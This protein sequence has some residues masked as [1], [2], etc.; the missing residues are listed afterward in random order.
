MRRVCV[1]VVST[2]LGGGSIDRGRACSQSASSSLDRST[3]AGAPADQRASFAPQTQANRSIDRSIQPVHA[4]QE[5]QP[6]RPADGIE[7]DRS[8]A[9]GVRR[10]AWAACLWGRG[11]LPRGWCGP[12]PP[13][14]LDT[15]GRLRFTPPP[16]LAAGGQPAHHSSSSSHIPLTPFSSPIITTTASP[17]PTSNHAPPRRRR[18]LRPP[19]PAGAH[20]PTH[21]Y[22]VSYTWPAGSLSAQTGSSQRPWES[23]RPRASPLPYHT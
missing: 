10:R 11:W 23:D 2:W 6:D 20:T 3:R 21:M 8:S 5:R 13:Q 9:A 12:S 22:Y 4:K 7:A 19:G 15:P 16:L 14:H 1:A 18:R 17:D